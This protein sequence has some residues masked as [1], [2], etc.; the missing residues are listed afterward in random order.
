MHGQWIGHVL[1]PE[2]P[3]RRFGISGDHCAADRNGQ[4]MTVTASA[5]RIESAVRAPPVR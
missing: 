3:E 5:R 4:A 1:R 2:R